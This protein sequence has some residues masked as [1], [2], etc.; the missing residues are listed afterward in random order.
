MAF[1]PGGLLA[2]GW[3]QRRFQRGADVGLVRFTAQHIGADD[4]PFLP[5]A[6]I[7]SRHAEGG[8]LHHAGRGIA[9]HSRRILHGRKIAQHAKACKSS[10]TA[11]LLRA[12]LVDK[13]VD[14]RAAR[15][16][17]RFGKD[18]V[19]P[20]KAFQRAQKRPELRGGAGAAAV[21]G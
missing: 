15:V 20:V 2:E 9:H 4:A 14:G 6:D 16:R 19:Q 18:G 7:Y 21:S 12:R 3:A 10:P 13:G 17:I 8:R 5:R 1:C 11:R